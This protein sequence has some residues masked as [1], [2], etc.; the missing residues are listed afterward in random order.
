MIYYT[1]RRF[2]STNKLSLSN[3]KS[4]NMTNIKNQG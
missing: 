3:E 2:E 1:K 4:Y